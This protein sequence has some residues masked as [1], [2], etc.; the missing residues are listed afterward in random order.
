MYRDLKIFNTREA[1]LADLGSTTP[2]NV[3]ASLSIPS[4]PSISLPAPVTENVPDYV[5]TSMNLTYL[6]ARG[7]LAIDW[8][9]TS[10]D[11]L[12]FRL[13]SFQPT[14]D[15]KSSLIAAIDDRHTSLSALKNQINA[16][17]DLE[18]V[19]GLVKSIY[20]DYRIYAKN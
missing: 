11:L 14:A 15:Q 16:G 10:L 8:R 20:N 12:K 9:L 4:T 2:I 6:K 17:T 1:C 3:Y 19:R 18:T 13:N 5:N 7:K